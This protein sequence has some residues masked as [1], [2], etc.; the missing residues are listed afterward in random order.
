M[1]QTFFKCNILEGTGL[2]N[3]EPQNND[4]NIVMS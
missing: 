3:P 4:S 1:V 2:T